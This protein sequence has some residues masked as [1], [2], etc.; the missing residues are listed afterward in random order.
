MSLLRGQCGPGTASALEQYPGF[1]SWIHSG[2]CLLCPLI[3]RGDSCT[4]SPCQGV[5]GPHGTE[6]DPSLPGLLPSAGAFAAG[7]RRVALQPRLSLS[8]SRGGRGCLGRGRRRRLRLLSDA[9][10]FP[11]AVQ[12]CRAAQTQRVGSQ[13][14]TRDAGQGLRGL[15]SGQA[16]GSRPRGG[17]SAADSPGAELE[18]MGTAGMGETA[19]GTAV[20]AALQGP[21]WG[22]STHRLRSRQGGSGS[23]LLAAPPAFSCLSFCPVVAGGPGGVCAGSCRWWGAGVSAV[24]PPGQVGGDGSTNLPVPLAGLGAGGDQLAWTQPGGLSGWWDVAADSTWG[25]APSELLGACLWPGL[26]CPSPQHGPGAAVA[27]SRAGS[28]PAVSHGTL[29][30]LG[31]R[32]GAAEGADDGSMRLSRQLVLECLDSP[33]HNK[34]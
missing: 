13:P 19:G 34:P 31:R 24:Q 8:T 6:E 29:L 33:N 25:Q 21:L 18:S 26:G 14:R 23:A 32:E 5:E 16:L 11:A 1:C 28:L 30:L 4:G 12:A 9:F 27:T 15:T 10:A 20:S 7:W 17:L 3:S 22:I 2:G